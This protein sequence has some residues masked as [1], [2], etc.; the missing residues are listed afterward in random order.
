MLE[1]QEVLHKDGTH[2]HPRQ[3]VQ[4]RAEIEERKGNLVQLF[5]HRIRIYKT[6][7]NL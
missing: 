5:E 6:S 2:D 7:Y 4:G 1:V 3:G